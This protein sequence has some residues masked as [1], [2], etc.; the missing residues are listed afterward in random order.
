MSNY[1][2]FGF[3]YPDG[4]PYNDANPD[5]AIDAVRNR[6]EFLNLCHEMT[7]RPDGFLMP[8]HKFAAAMDL[9]QK[10]S[11][12][13]IDTFWTKVALE[14]A[15]VEVA[16]IAD[17]LYYKV[18]DTPPLLDFPNAIALF[19]CRFVST[20]E[21]EHIR[22]YSIGGSE[23]GTVLGLSHFQS[24]RSL[25]H[26]KKTV[27]TNVHDAGTQQIF[28]YGHAVE[29]YT[30]AAVADTLGGKRYPE[31][32]MFAH[33]KYPFITCNPDGIL[34]FPDGHYALFEAKTATRWKLDDWRNGI[35]DYYEPQP[36]QYLEVLDD[37]RLTEGYIGC[38]FGGLPS[39]MK[40]YKYYRDAAA[41]AAQ[42]EQI[43]KFWNDQIVPGVLPDF[44]GDPE[45]DM[46]AEYR[47]V[48]R[49]TLTSTDTLPSSCAADFARYYDLQAKHYA[50]TQDINKAKAEEEKYL[51]MI[52][53]SAA[54]GLTICTV[55][56]GITY[57]IKCSP[58]TR[59]SVDTQ[60][61]PGY[62]LDWLL[63][64]AEALRNHDVSY[65]FPKVSKA[66]KKAP[67]KSRKKTT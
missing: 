50:L 65:S 53:P 23:A 33:K 11:N 15:P 36:R 29:D 42:I 28:D 43:V 2:P 22:R 66:V 39:D 54:D 38:C 27:T 46:E 61:L 17:A 18:K 56:G 62:L 16:E 3:T 52:K 10:G 41:G 30:V 45:L 55:P 1:F 26:E 20:K 31:F 57:R 67:A 48:Q 8:G 35:P 47:Y 51:D 12:L 37:P 44:C 63:S 9:F 60:V 5:P 25:Y 32:R 34:V 64:R 49:R 13:D 14:L 7:I 19:D 40:V 4:F 59:E 58:Y 6:M 24:R 21:W